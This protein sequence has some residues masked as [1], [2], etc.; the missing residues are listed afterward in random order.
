M[1]L[2]PA[3]SAMRTDISRWRAEARAS[4]RLAILAQ[5]SI[6]T[7][8]ARPSRICRGWTR[9]RLLEGSP[10]PAVVQLDLGDGFILGDGHGGSGRGCEGPTLSAAVAW[11]SETPGWARAIN[12]TQKS[13]LLV[14][15]S[16]SP[17][18]GLRTLIIGERDKELR[19][20]GTGAVR[21]GERC[22]VDADDGEGRHVD[23]DGFAQNVGRAAEGVVP[24]CVRDDGHRSR[25]G[26][27]VIGGLEQAA[28]LGLKLHLREEVAADELCLGHAGGAVCGDVDAVDR[29]EGE[30]LLGGVG[31]TS[32]L[33][34]DGVGE[35]VEVVAAPIAEETVA[36]GAVDGG[37]VVT[38]EDEHA[39]LCGVRRAQPD[40]EHLVGVRKDGG[41]G[42]DGEGQRGD[43]DGG[44]A[45]TLFEDAEGVDGVGAE[46]VQPAQA[47]GGADAILVGGDCAE[48]ETCAAGGLAGGE[49]LADQV[50]G[51]ALQVEAEL[52]G[53]V[54]LQLAAEE[55]G[56]D[57]AAEAGPE[58]AHSE[59]SGACVRRRMALTIF[60]M[61]VHFSVSSSNCWRPV[62]ER[63]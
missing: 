20:A 47:E 53:H 15:T 37:M 41:V 59:T 60:A 55:D 52:G 22:G 62:A 42:A 31:V 26:D 4:M 63:L 24:E 25:R 28:K 56:V 44:E 16:F 27:S 40:I 43:G 46:F 14:R 2:R 50:F 5:A 45:G 54:V 11:A 61:R 12:C 29:L 3:P 7:N 51:A 58:L 6:R 9:A 34:E 10:R 36:P 17:F 13:D 19:R 38:G 48:L 21:A 8:P 18:M 33:L 57:G 49:A 23:G 32:K 39:Q 35:G 30:D 1:R